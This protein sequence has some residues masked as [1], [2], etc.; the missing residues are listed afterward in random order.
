[1]L[2]YFVL[3]RMAGVVENLTVFPDRMRENFDRSHGLVFSQRVS[4][5]KLAGSGFEFRHRTI[6][7]A[8]RSELE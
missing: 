3:V 7:E 6:D 4:S 1:M 2:A 8:F 5:D